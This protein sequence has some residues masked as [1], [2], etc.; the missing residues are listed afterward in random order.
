M[1]TQLIRWWT[2]NIQTAWVDCCCRSEFNYVTNNHQNEKRASHENSRHANDLQGVPMCR[3]RLTQAWNWDSTFAC[4]FSDVQGEHKPSDFGHH[5]LALNLRSLRFV[6][7]RFE[8][9]SEN[10]AFDHHAKCRRLTRVLVPCSTENSTALHK[11]TV[12]LLKSLSSVF[13]G[14]FPKHIR[15][16][17]Q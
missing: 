5:T 4:K 15:H 12:Q 16:H 9:T 2:R 13:Y 7:C 10:C 3:L 17:S 11:L 14:T 6:Q 1:E 8:R